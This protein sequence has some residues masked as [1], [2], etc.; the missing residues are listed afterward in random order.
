MQ[1]LVMHSIVTTMGQ[2]FSTN[3][4]KMHCNAFAVNNYVE[5]KYI[6]KTL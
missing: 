6:I 4:P 2:M 1:C 5:E 3:Y